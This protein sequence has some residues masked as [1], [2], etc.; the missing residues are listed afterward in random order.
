M[1]FTCPHCGRHDVILVEN[2]KAQ[3]YTRVYISNSGARTLDNSPDVE[4]QG[5]PIGGWYEC[6]HC[7][8]L[9]TD[10]TENIK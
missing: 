10:I 4:V 8:K 5:E 2:V 3:R 9:V 1:R 7:E 6:P